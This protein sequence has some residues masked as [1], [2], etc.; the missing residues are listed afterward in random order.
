M[1][2]KKVIAM[3]QYPIASI[4]DLDNALKAQGYLFPSKVVS[5]VFSFEFGRVH[6][7]NFPIM[8][9]GE[10]V[11]RIGQSIRCYA[12]ADYYR[13]F[14]SQD[15]EPMGDTDFQR[16]CNYLTTHHPIMFTDPIDKK[17]YVYDWQKPLQNRGFL[18]R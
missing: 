4:D 11:N 10:Q 17:V 1:P 2:T 12:E 13:F 7:A 15:R 8:L 18:V 6:Q 16:L 3:N 14:A 9:S 5:N